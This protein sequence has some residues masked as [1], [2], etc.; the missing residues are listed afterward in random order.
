MYFKDVGIKKSEKILAVIFFSQ[1]CKLINCFVH[2]KECI[3]EYL[4]I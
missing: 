2:K 3:S 4:V 1:V